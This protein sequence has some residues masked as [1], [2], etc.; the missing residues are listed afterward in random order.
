MKF[1]AETASLIANM[2]AKIDALETALSEKT[3]SFNF[4]YEYAQKKEKELEE[5]KKKIAALESKYCAITNA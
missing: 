4:W 3:E 5:L 1:D 2:A